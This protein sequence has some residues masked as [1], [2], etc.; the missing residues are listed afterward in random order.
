MARRQIAGLG[1]IRKGNLAINRCF[2][3]LCRT[4]YLPGRESSACNREL[5]CRHGAFPGQ[6]CRM[7]TVARTL[8]IDM[9]KSGH[10]FPR[11]WMTVGKV[12]RRSVCASMQSFAGVRD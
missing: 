12:W 10:A 2:E 4:L 7:Q 6:G 5:A 8:Y 9:S 11:V 1:D 3:H